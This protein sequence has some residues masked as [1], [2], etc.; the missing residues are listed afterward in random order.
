[1][2]QLDPGN[3]EVTSFSTD[4]STAKL[5]AQQPEVSAPPMICSCFGS[6][7]IYCGDQLAAQFAG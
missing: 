2:A 3:L 6:C 1:M 7:D 4:D 5:M